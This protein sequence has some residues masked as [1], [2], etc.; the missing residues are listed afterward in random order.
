MGSIISSIFYRCFSFCF[1]RSPNQN[2]HVRL[3]DIEEGKPQ[4]LHTGPTLGPTPKRRALLV[5][6]SYRHSQSEL[7]WPLENPHK[8]VD[9]FRDLLVRKYVIICEALMTQR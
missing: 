7:W 5:G 1:P 4:R 9:M 2:R 8:D 6:I 3:P